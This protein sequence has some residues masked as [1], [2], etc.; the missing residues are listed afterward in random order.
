MNRISLIGL[1]AGALLA[2]ATLASATPGNALA[3]SGGLGENCAQGGQRGKALF[4]FGASVPLPGPGSAMQAP[5]AAPLQV[6]GG[7]CGAAASRA[8]ASQGGKVIGSPKAVQRGGRTVCVVTVLI[9]DPKGKKPP[10][11]R[12]VTVPAN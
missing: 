2:T 1:F 8:A 3:C 10:T 7:G 5:Q 6:A 9:K 12:Q 11:R 4:G